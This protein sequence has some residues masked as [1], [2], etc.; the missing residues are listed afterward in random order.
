MGASRTD[1]NG[2][3]LVFHLS[4]GFDPFQT[5]Q[6]QG[7]NQS[8]AHFYQQIGPSGKKLSFGMVEQGLP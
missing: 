1:E 4:Q 7:A 5:N 6:G 8:A 2:L 3:A